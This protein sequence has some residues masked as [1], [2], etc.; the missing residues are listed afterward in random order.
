[1][2]WNAIPQANEPVMMNQ[3]RASF[4]SSFP[5][6]LAGPK[7]KFAGSVCATC[8]ASYPSNQSDSAL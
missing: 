5:N 2:L 3:L 4:R 1:M 7:K 8:A 6:S